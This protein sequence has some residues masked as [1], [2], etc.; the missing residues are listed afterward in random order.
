MTT[1]SSSLFL[2]SLSAL[3]DRSRLRI[4]RILGQHE[5]SVGEI[6][7]VVQLPQSTASRHLKLLFEA[8]FVSRRTVGTTGLYRISSEM[9]VETRELWEIA[10]NNVNSVPGATE[11]DARLVAILAERHA[12]SRTFFQNIGSEWESFRRELF[13]SDFTSLAL[14]SLI[15]PSLRVVD[16]GCGIGNAAL[17]IA[18]YVQNVVGIDRESTMIE[19]AKTRPDIAPNIAFKVGEATK[20]PLQDSEVDIALFCLVLHHIDATK[21]AIAEASRVVN[22]GGRILIVDMQQHT[23]DEYKHTMGHVH[24]GF[25]S[26]DVQDLAQDAQCSLQAY[27]RMPPKI[28]ARGPSLFT[29]ILDVHH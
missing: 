18:P 15:D 22:S 28:D 9:P 23:R 19:Q 6:A 24:L 26:D 5:L 29:A 8:R 21:N 3:N 2:D 25:S 14:L 4:L 10:T 27:H 13:G 12:D 17:M 20:L 7:G 16:I 11:D 1:I